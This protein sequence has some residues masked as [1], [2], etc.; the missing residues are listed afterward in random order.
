MRCRVDVSYFFA[1]APGLADHGPGNDLGTKLLASP[2]GVSIA[3]ALRSAAGEAARRGDVL[4]G[5][6]CRAD[7]G[8]GGVACRGTNSPR[9]GCCCGDAAPLHEDE[10][11][12]GFYRTR[13]FRGGP[14]EPVAIW[15]DAD[16]LNVL[17]G[18]R[19][20]EVEKVWP[21]CARRPIPHS[22]Y[23]AVAERGENWPDLDAVV[24]EQEARRA[25]ENA[26]R[27][28]MTDPVVAAQNSERERI[29]GNYPPDEAVLIKDQIESAAAGASAYATIV[30]DETLARAQTLRSR[31]AR[32][33]GRRGK[34][35]QA[36]KAAAPRSRP[37]GRPQMF[38]LRDRAEAVAMTIR[39]AMEAWETVKLQ[40]R[41][42]EE[43]RA[44]EL[45]PPPTEIAI[46]SSPPPPRLDGWRRQSRA[47]PG[48]ASSRPIL[49]VAEV[50]DWMALFNFCRERPE[51]Q[52]LLKK[53]AAQALNSGETVPG[54][55]SEERSKVA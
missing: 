27:L 34:A 52:D 39:R 47:A 42:E 38:S 29:G 45:S 15:R 37:R 25:Q 35:T 28:A 36:G 20:V 17:C 9:I 11:V 48:G 55:R 13:R 4:A 32:T 18:G 10:P 7:R 46:S 2:Y 23:L 26:A 12:P 22:W 6:G 14:Y 50:T 43:R 33:Q 24:A 51:V 16:G 19:P 3:R 53:L 40:R 1:G 21:H 30:D 54:V 5:P 41:R 8:G 31:P 49:V 44:L